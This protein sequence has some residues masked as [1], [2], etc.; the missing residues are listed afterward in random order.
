[1]GDEMKVDKDVIGVGKI[2]VTAE[3][4]GCALCVVN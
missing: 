4:T 3:L 1:M 2:V